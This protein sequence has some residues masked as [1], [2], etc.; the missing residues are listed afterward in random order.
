MA[1]T[2]FPVRT[3]VRTTLE[4]RVEDWLGRFPAQHATTGKQTLQPSLKQNRT[5]MFYSPIIRLALGEARL[6]FRPLDADA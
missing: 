1:R 3:S 5:K 6:S 2:S 4:I